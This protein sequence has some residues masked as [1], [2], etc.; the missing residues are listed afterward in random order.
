MIFGLGKNMKKIFISL[1]LLFAASSLF[2]VEE[3]VSLIYKQIDE[4]FTSRSS[5]RLDEILRDNINDKYYYLIE[6]YTQKKIRRLILTNDYQFAQDTT[7]VVIDNNL[8]NTDAV[9]MYSL[10]IEAYEIQKESEAKKEQ[11]RIDAELKVEKEKEKARS[12]TEKLY[13]GTK[14]ASGTNI[15]M[16]SEKDL[17]FTRYEWKA[18]LGLFNLEAMTVENGFSAGVNYDYNFRNLTT[19]VDLFAGANLFYLTQLSGD[20]PLVVTIEAIPRISLTQIS[21]KV[22]LR[23]GFM[24]YIISVSGNEKITYATPVLGVQMN[25]IKLGPMNIHVGFDYYPFHLWNPNVVLAFGLNAGLEIPFTELDRTEWYLT[26]GMKDKFFIDMSNPANDFN[27]WNK[28]H[29]VIGIGAK[30]VIR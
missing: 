29:F 28:L 3:Y 1:V 30:N 9:E 24:D 23:A 26:I 2:A 7:L 5:E 25:Q 20:P 19:G 14:S 12:S 27:E 4:A 22:F 17:N 16:S 6:N 10:I 8:D 21:R 13:E 18:Q 15:Y 11:A